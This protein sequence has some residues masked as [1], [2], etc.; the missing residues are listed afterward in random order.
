MILKK[1][2]KQMNLIKDSLASFRLD[3]ITDHY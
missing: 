3:L 2:M 1:N